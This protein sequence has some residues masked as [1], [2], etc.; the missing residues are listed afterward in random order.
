MSTHCTRIPL[1][2]LLETD[3]IL[4]KLAEQSS[5]DQAASPTSPVL[6]LSPQPDQD[7]AQPDDHPTQQVTSYSKPPFS[8]FNLS[9]NT[10]FSPF[11]K[12]IIKSTTSYC[13][14]IEDYIS[15]KGEEATSKQT[16]L[17]GNQARLKD[18]AVLLNK[19][20]STLVQEAHQIR[21]LLELID[22][23]IPSILK[24]SLESAA[25]LDDYFAIVRKANKNISSRA[26]L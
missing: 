1:S 10:H 8:K 2:V 25:R 20:I 23:G 21:Y 9:A 3:E 15:E 24:A 12:N 4:D 19:D 7:T 17:M 22:Q 18:I 5:S 13:F 14:T 6:Q 16:L 26:T 11:L